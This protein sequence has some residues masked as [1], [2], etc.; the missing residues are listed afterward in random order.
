[1]ARISEY[2]VE[3]LFIE[4]LESIGYEYVDL[5]NYDEVLNNFKEQL[6]K[7]NKN[8]LLEKKGKAEL[9]KTEFERVLTFVENKTVYESAKILRDKYILSL[10]NGETVYLDFFSADTTRN[11]YQV[12]H[13]ITM[14]KN[15]KDDVDYKNRYDVTVLING[16]PLVQIELKR[17][18]V[19]INEAINQINRYRK[20]SFKGLFRYLQIFV[21]SNSVQTKYFCNEN[22]IDNGKY[23]PILK[24]LVFFWTDEKNMR[25]NSLND[26][27]AEF[28]RKTAL[29]EMIDKYMVIK[30]TEPVLMVMRPYQIFA[31]KEAKKRI[32]ES[33]QNGYVFACTGSGKT[34][35]SF[36][37]AQLLREEARIDKVVF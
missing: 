35:T 5:A 6:T 30:T 2:E 8:K 29:T 15:H 22:E 36:K 27:T 12:A 17:P 18:G 1:M 11:L 3:N 13:Q 23:N 20:F 28:F 37:L 10:D 26:F 31:V 19:E 7:F 32:L 25:I 24:S 33:N 14:D 21:V 4:R 9:S 16:L 34:L